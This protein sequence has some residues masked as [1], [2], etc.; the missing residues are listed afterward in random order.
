[1]TEISKK[2]KSKTPAIAIILFLVFATVSFAQERQY[3]AKA[4]SFG[5][6]G[7][8]QWTVSSDPAGSNPNLV[9][10]SIIDQIEDQFIKRGVK[11]VFQM[12]DGENFLSEAGISTRAAAAKRL[13]EAGIGFFPMRGNHATYFLAKPSPSDFLLPLER[14]SF[15]QTQGRANT[16]GTRNFSSPVQVSKD[17]D[18]LSYSFDYGPSGSSARFVVIDVM[19]T[20]SSNH[21]D[22]RSIVSYGYPIGTQQN[23]IHTRLNKSTTQAFVLTHQP[24]IAE[25]HADS[26]FGGL[27]DENA[28]EQNA[29]MSSLQ[30]AGVKYY[31]SAH[32]HVDQRSMITSP[33]GRSRI[34]E[35]ISAPA[36]PKFY[37]PAASTDR[38]WNGQKERETPLSQEMN[39][40]GFYIFTVD[41]PR[42]NVDYYSDQNGRYMSDNSWPL[43]PVNAGSLITPVFNFVKKESWGYSLNGREFLIAQGAS[44]TGVTDKFKKTTMRILRGINNSTAADYNGRHFVKKV[45]T[46]W[47]RKTDK[48]QK[49]EIVSLWG[50]ADL[51]S[52]Q[53]DTYV[54]SLSFNNRNRKYLETGR[55]G[56][57]T[58]DSKGHWV[59]AVDKNSGGEKRFVI[60][61]YNPQYGLGTY[62][63]DPA[64]K[65]AW[66]IINYNADFVVLEDM[67]P[68]Q[69]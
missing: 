56:I 24:L 40:I 28:P 11:F 58:P 14:S 7:D 1:M 39:D 13:Y 9:S 26:A 34:E 38:K 69:K 30:A 5:V 61:P 10:V 36:C 54:L 15:P 21:L 68:A 43:G 60:G 37:T 64:T 66:A 35:L 62:G 31:I 33:D 20:P 6:M 18:G 48:K 50:M 17:L 53:T 25:N 32:D 52:G 19:A 51:G 46:G 22:K 3:G 2:L 47:S 29:F 63:V 57:A 65:T 16:F 55:L 8:T 42:V 4:W 67:E 23:W 12:G 41:G 49:S 45:S 27:V 44:Y 59:N